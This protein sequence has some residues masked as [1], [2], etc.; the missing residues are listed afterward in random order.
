MSVSTLVPSLFGFISTML[1]IVL[2]LISMGKGKEEIL[3][4]MIW[5][6]VGTLTLTLLWLFGSTP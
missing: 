2:F 1:V 4:V 6:L 3:P 5:S